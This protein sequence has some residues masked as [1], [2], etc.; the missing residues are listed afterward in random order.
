LRVTVWTA[1]TTYGHSMLT[2]CLWMTTA[3]IRTEVALC[4]NGRDYLS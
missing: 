3:A 2:D 1:L 4:P